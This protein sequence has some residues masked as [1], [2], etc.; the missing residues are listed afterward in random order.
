M[1]VPELIVRLKNTLPP[2]GGKPADAQYRQAVIEGVRDL[3]LR[4]PSTKM[5]MIAVVAGTSEYTLPAD[6]VKLEDFPPLSRFTQQGVLVTSAGLIPLSNLTS[7]RYSVRNA[8]LTIYPSPTYTL[9]RPL[10]YGAGYVIATDDMI[11]DLSDL[12]ADVA[13]HKV[14]SLLLLQ[15]AD[16]VARQ[17]WRYTIGDETVDKVSLVNE[18][19]KQAETEMGFYTSALNDRIPQVTKTADYAQSEWGSFSGDIRR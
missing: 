1:K 5:V 13:M 8:K 7:E 10:W 6:F 4:S 3:G 2:Q 15:I 12:D 17:A 14:N 11:T 19:R 18:L 9:S 16:G